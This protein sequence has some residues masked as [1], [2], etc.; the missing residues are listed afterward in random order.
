LVSR[1]REDHKNDIVAS[2]KWIIHSWKKIFV[3]LG[4]THFDELISLIDSPPFISFA[5]QLGYL[6]IIA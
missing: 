5:T 1:I 3:T 6:E 2:K 4:S